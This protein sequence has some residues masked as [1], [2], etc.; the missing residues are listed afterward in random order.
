MTACASCSFVQS[1][2]SCFVV[3]RPVSGPC[4]L[5]RN[6]R[7]CRRPRRAARRRAGTRCPRRRSRA[8]AASTSASRPGRS[9]SSGVPLAFAVS[10]GFLP[11]T[12]QPSCEPCALSSD[13]ERAEHHRGGAR[14]AHGVGELR[15]PRRE[16]RRACGLPER[17]DRD[18]A[19]EPRGRLAALEQP[20]ERGL[21]L[22]GARLGELRERVLPLVTVDARSV[23]QHARDARV[24]LRLRH[25]GHELRA[26]L[27]RDLEERAERVVE[28]GRSTE[29]DGRLRDGPEVGAGADDIDEANVTGGA[30]EREP[31]ARLVLHDR[32]VRGVRELSA[33][34]RDDALRD[35]ELGR[36]GVGPSDLGRAC[37]A[38][39]RRGGR[40]PCTPRARSRVTSTRHAS[41][42]DEER[43]TA[44]WYPRAAR[45][46]LAKLCGVVTIEPCRSASPWASSRAC[47][48]S[49][50]ASASS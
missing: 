23:D 21:H 15:D 20:R 2:S 4:S 12:S 9:I 1:G 37:R 3:S 13:V 18:G 36:P 10:S 7:Q 34:Q 19:L 29:V 42:R 22:G 17:R 5:Q 44:R 14:L 46:G 27:A 49:S 35:R 16:R 8:S 39:A 41:F 45:Y 30:N 25:V 43:S 40:R 31:R 38:A 11:S 47:G 6:V 28:V 33:R 32:G 50:A 48:R 26:P 24:A